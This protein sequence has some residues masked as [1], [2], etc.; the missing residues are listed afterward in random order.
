MFLVLGKQLPT[1]RGLNLL[2]V[3]DVWLIWQINAM[4]TTGKCQNVFSVDRKNWLSLNSCWNT[5]H[6]VRPLLAKKSLTWYIQSCVQILRMLLDRPFK[7][8]SLSKGHLETVIFRM[9]ASRLT[10]ICHI[11]AK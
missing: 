3:S 10:Y 1:I 6:V 4:N 9:I 7:K 5:S 11:W 8:I 2:L